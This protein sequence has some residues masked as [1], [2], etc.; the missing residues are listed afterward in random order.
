MTP[1]R[2]VVTGASGFVGRRFVALAGPSCTP[3]SLSASDW[4]RRIESADYAG[5]VVIHLAARAHRGG[6]AEQFQHDNVEK[7]RVLAQA[8]ARNGARRLVFLSSI[9]V[10]GEA[11][12]SR[13]FTAHDAPAP[14]DAYGRSKRDAELALAGIGAT[15]ALDTVIVRCPLVYGAPA[16][17][18][19]A[20]LLRA[21]DSAWPLPFASV[22]NRRSFIALDDLCRALLRCAS[23]E[24]AAG[25]TYL[26]A[27]RDAIST[28][29]LIRSVRGALGRPA[30][31]FAFPP[32]GLEFA[33]CAAGLGATMKRLTRSLEADASLAE[34]ELGWRAQ[35]GPDEAVAQMVREYRA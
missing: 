13:P 32:R 25:K 5:A 15:A 7:T 10:N 6:T 19:L 31:L 4:Q 24:A 27:H 9:K 29:G 30:R 35:T 18:H 2:Y 3:I 16:K 11:T 22:H 33:A 28:P 21:C 20:T 1:L 26:V 23:A 8:A 17:G 14:Q 34:T 12:A